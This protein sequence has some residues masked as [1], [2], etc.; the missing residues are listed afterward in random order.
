M[1][2]FLG[3]LDATDAAALRLQFDL[4]AWLGDLRAASPGEAAF[5]ASVEADLGE[6]FVL[7][8]QFSD[9]T[10]GARLSA[11]EGGGMVDGNLHANRAYFDSGTQT[12]MIPAGAS[13]RIRWKVP[14]LSDTSGWVFGLDNVR[15]ELFD[16]LKDAFDCNSDGMID[17]LDAN[18]APAVSLDGTLAAAGLIKGDADGD[19]QVQFSDFAILADNFNM[20]GPYTDGDFNKDGEI[21]FPDF[22]ILAKNFGQSSAEPTAVVPEPSGLLLSIFGLVATFLS[23]IRGRS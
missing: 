14:E 13:L 1:L 11:P 9:I 3:E 21:Q 12:A 17:V 23:R 5:D 15:L 8:H 10:T 16:S 22:L 18:C 7:L 2:Q 4:E 6:G 20:R 19:G